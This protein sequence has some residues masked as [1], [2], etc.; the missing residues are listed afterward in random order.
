MFLLAIKHEMRCLIFC[1]INVSLGEIEFG[2]SGSN[3]I[4]NLRKLAD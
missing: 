1:S 4:A 2:F 3:I